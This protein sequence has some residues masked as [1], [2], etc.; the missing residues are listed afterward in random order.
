MLRIALVLLTLC[1]LLFTPRAAP[2]R[3]AGSAT[4]SPV[5]TPALPI[6]PCMDNIGRCRVGPCDRSPIQ[7]STHLPSPRIVRTPRGIPICLQRLPGNASVSGLTVHSGWAAWTI[8]TI[9]GHR[10]S[11]RPRLYL[12]RLEDFRPSIIASPACS[13]EI[14]GP[15]LSAHWLA[16]TESHLTPFDRHD[17]LTI[18]AMDLSSHRSA[19]WS[20]PYTSQVLGPG[21]ALDGDTLVWTRQQWEG[22]GE[23]RSLVYGI[24]ARTLPD[25]P[26]RTI[27][28]IHEHIGRFIPPSYVDGYVA[29]HLAGALLVWQ[30]SRWQN[31]TPRGDIMAATLPNGPVRV[32]AW[33]S[34]ESPVTN[35]WKVAWLSA[36]GNS[37]DLMQLDT[38]TGKRNTIG[39]NVLPWTLSPRMGGTTLSWQSGRRG[40]SWRLLL[41]RD[42]L[43]GRQYTLVN[44]R[45]AGATPTP[46]K[47]IGP[48]TADGNRVVWEEIVQGSM[49][50]T[51]AYLAV[52]SVPEHTLPTG[53]PLSERPSP[54]P[55]R[56][57]QGDVDRLPILRVVHLD[58]PSAR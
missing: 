55:A 20:I 35:G 24:F 25:G 44:W 14:G 4:P 2:L 1:A 38:H 15:Y 8:P 13:T 50:K 16:W 23:T 32:V 58:H 3:A 11:L 22:Q 45:A 10:N 41:V 46:I 53:V 19:S 9:S 5:A 36:R 29:P 17:T 12:A 28:V 18:R 51:A 21:V 33:N 7:P 40:K 48:G 37:L 54:R 49:Q 34:A 42:L 47:A 26:I 39:H 56:L 27:Q 43:S 57:G 6:P 52:A 31:S 30:R